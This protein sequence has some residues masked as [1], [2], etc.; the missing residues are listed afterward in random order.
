VIG[1]RR[2]AER[3]HTEILAALDK[4]NLVGPSKL[5]VADYLNDWLDG[6]VR[7]VIDK[8]KTQQCYRMIATR[9]LIPSLGRIKLAKLSVMDV[10]TYYFDMLTGGRGGSDGKLTG[11]PLSPKT[12]AHRHIVFHE[13]LEN[14][15]KRGIVGRNVANRADSPWTKRV[16][17]NV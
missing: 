4:G 11:K 17:I 8:P 15:L 16:E 2:D 3:K 1:T 13:A 6:Y 10:Q 14:A 5:T 7:T 9:H 12:I